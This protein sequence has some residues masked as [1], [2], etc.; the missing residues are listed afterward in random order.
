[1]D[2]IPRTC[3][4]TR[5]RRTTT[6]TRTTRR[7]AAP[8][9]SSFSSSSSFNQGLTLYFIDHFSPTEFLE[10][11]STYT[12][13]T[14]SRRKSASVAELRIKQNIA[15]ETKPLYLGKRGGRGPAKADSRKPPKPPST[16]KSSK[17]KASRKNPPRSAKE[18]KKS[19]SPARGGGGVPPLPPSS[20]T[21]SR[22]AAADKKRQQMTPST[23]ET[24]TNKTPKTVVA[25][26]VSNK[27]AKKKPSPLTATKKQE[28]ATAPSASP[29]GSG[30]LDVEYVPIS[31]QRGRNETPPTVV[32]TKKMPVNERHGF[33][34]PT[35]AR[36][37]GEN[38]DETLSTPPPRRPAV[39]FQ[40]MSRATDLFL[41]SRDGAQ[42]SP[43]CCSPFSIHSLDS[44]SSA[45][46]LF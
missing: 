32:R 10:F 23:A 39:Q 36:R 11:I 6:T 22:M 27:V 15:D 43:S 2:P 16:R 31:A 14:V 4:Y 28:P 18:S 35:L 13:R 45:G 33:N 30:A 20:R 19:R 38:A 26:K 46:S 40:Q 1:M 17:P 44:A 24:N 9:T 8:T 21:R 7:R 25:S 41:H 29:P 12:M 3:R 37:G 5:S 42:L 34:S